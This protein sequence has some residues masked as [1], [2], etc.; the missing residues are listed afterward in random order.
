MQSY[1][2]EYVKTSVRLAEHEGH[3]AINTHRN[4]SS[5]EDVPTRMV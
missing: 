5:F 3:N 1:Q 2:P 4:A